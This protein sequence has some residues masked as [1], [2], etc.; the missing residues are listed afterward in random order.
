MGHDRVLAADHETEASLE[1]EDPA[2]RADVDVV[3]APRAQLGR[4]VD[5]VAV[6]GVAPVDDDVPRIHPRRQIGDRRPGVGGGHHDPGGTRE[7]EGC[8]ERV[9]IA[10]PGDGVA[11]GGEGRRDVGID[12]VD[13]AGVAVGHEPADQVGAHAAEADHSELHVRESLRRRLGVTRRRTH[14]DT[15]GCDSRGAH[16]PN[17]R[18]GAQP[19]CGSGTATPDHI[20][21]WILGPAN[22]NRFR[23]SRRNP[24]ARRRSGMSR[25]R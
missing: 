10:G 5:V 3:D 19:G 15:P 17:R 21:D 2:A 7:L 16:G 25:V 13:D 11:L 20:A 22:W 9:E 23:A 8:D 14:R 6:V 12:V 1:T 24:A 4:P 18:A